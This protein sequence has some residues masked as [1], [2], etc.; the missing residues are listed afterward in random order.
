MAEPVGTALDPTVIHEDESVEV[1]Y[2]YVVLDDGQV[3]RLDTH[4]DEWSPAPPVPDTPAAAE[5][6]GTWG[7]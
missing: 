1:G 7:T 2:L 3:W 4:L 5:V 6:E